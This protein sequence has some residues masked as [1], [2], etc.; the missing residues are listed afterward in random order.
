[1]KEAWKFL[2]IAVGAAV[3][4]IFGT[5]LV[6]FYIFTGN[7]GN[8]SKKDLIQN[9]DRHWREINEVKRYMTSITPIND[10]VEIEFA[11]DNELDTFYLNR[12]SNAN[13]K[14]DSP[15]TD[16]LLRKLGWTKEKLVTL[17]AKLDDANCTSVSTGE[18]F[19]VGYQQNGLGMYYYK[20]FSKPLNDSLKREYNNGCEYIFYK[21]NIVLAYEGG[22]IGMQCFE[23]YYKN[24]NN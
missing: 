17:K 21:D 8:Y 20:I 3:V 7:V 9:Y 16:S 19:T 5:L 10:T 14:I 1:M 15:K 18:P 22:A 12:E 11:S 4:I 24:K 6:L 23:D 2:A 13:L